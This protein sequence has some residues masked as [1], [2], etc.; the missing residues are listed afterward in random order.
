MERNHERMTVRR[1]SNNHNKDLKSLFGSSA[2]PVSAQVLAPCAANRKQI[3]VILR[4]ESSL[5]IFALPSFAFVASEPLSPNLP[6]RPG[7]RSSP[8]FADFS[9]N[10]G[11]N[12]CGISRMTKLEVHASTDEVHLEHRAAPRGAGDGHQHRLRAVERMTRE[13]G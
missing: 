5:T 1:L 2:I 6:A 13:I 4:R 3:M 11:D 8:A 7:N 10:R 12:G 9:D